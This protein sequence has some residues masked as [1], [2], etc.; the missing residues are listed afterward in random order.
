MAIGLFITAGIGLTV[1]PVVARALL[2]PWTLVLLLPC[3]AFFLGLAVL[4]APVAAGYYL[5][6]N[7]SVQSTTPLKASRALAFS[8]PAAW[9]AVLTRSQWTQKSPQS[10]KQLHPGSPMVS[11]AL[12]EI[13]IMIVRDFVLIWYTQISSSP[14]FPTAVSETLNSSLD[15]LLQRAA[16]MDHA[17]LVVKRILPKLTAHIEQFRRS[18]VA[19]RGATLERR[20]TASEELD[21]LLASRYA[22]KGRLHLAVGNLSSAFTKQTEEAHLRGLVERALPHILPEAEARSPAVCIVMREIVA[23]SVLYPVVDMLSDPDFWNKMIDSMVLYSM[24][25]VVVVL[26]QYPG[27]RGYS[28]AVGNYFPSF[29]C[30]SLSYVLRIRRLISKVRSVLESQAPRRNPK[31]PDVG[32][33]TTELITLRTDLKHFESFLRSIDRISSLLD[34]RRLKNDIANEIRRTRALLGKTPSASQS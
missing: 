34:V 6:H 1:G 31:T 9:Q 13:L 2:S 7:R 28:S 16:A 15:R 19:L 4:L 5:D 8:T 3:L 27:W 11:S 30:T 26:T 32:T 18:E 21:M 20:L 33:P 14:S 23:C 17:A 24:H 10:L 12:N 25:P 22:G 29:C